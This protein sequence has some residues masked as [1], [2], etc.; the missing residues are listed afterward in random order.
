MRKSRTIIKLGPGMSMLQARVLEIAFFW[1]KILTRDNVKSM[2]VDSVCNCD[3]PAVFGFQP[4]SME[5]IVPQYLDGAVA[6]GRYQLF[7]HRAGRSSGSS[8]RAQ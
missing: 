6:R 2:R 1:N 3:F 5:A 7:R 8:G 4:A